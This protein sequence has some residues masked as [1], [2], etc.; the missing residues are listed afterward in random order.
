MSLR[1]ILCIVVS[2]LLHVLILIQP[3]VIM[4]RTPLLER[5]PSLPVRLVNI[6]PELR[7][8]IEELSPDDLLNA[9]ELEQP[10]EGVS[11]VAEGGVAT[12]YLDMLKVK[13]FRVWEYPEDAIMRGEQGKVSISFV[14]NNKGVVVDIGVLRSSGSHSLDTAAMAA[15]EQ[16][17]P[18]G[19]FSSDIRGQTLKVTGNFMY[20]LD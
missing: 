10:E 5:V 20:V 7:E 6:P 12:G 11:M 1:L 2:S 19:P 4:M 9:P 18:Y 17:S 15:I 8:S 16:A 14:L 13:V 3:A